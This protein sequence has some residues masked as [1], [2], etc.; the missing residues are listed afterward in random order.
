MRIF[1]ISISIPESSPEIS[2]EPNFSPNDI[3]R[4]FSSSPMPLSEIIA[5]HHK[6]EKLSALSSYSSGRFFINSSPESDS[7]FFSSE[8]MLYTLRFRYLIIMLI[9]FRNSSSI[10]Q[11]SQ[12]LFSLSDALIPDKKQHI[13]IRQIPVILIIMIFS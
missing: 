3:R 10:L 8:I 2:L 4:L 5:L 7:L 6:S 11:L 13:I 12:Y 9:L 1:S